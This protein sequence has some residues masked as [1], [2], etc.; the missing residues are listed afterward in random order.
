MSLFKADKEMK[1]KHEALK[2]DFEASAEK[3]VELEAALDGAKLKLSAS[4]SEKE[5]LEQ[6]NAELVESQADFD[7]KLSKALAAKLAEHGSDE[8]APIEPDQESARE[9][10]LKTY[11]AMEPG[12]ERSRLR[13]ENMEYFR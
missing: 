5:E 10:F 13:R 1:E 6:R 12:A 9:E 7:E 11:A 4:E 8:P 2:A 3:I